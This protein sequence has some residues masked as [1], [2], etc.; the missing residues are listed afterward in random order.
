MEERRGKVL[1]LDVETGQ[2]Q[3]GFL[4]LGR[5]FQGPEIGL[6]AAVGLPAWAAARASVIASIVLSAAIAS[7]W[8]LANS[9]SGPA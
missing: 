7:A 3:V 1:L 5:V 6:P 2:G 4:Q 9:F 8:P